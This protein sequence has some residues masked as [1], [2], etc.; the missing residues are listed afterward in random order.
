[1]IYTMNEKMETTKPKPGI[2]DGAVDATRRHESLDQ[3]V[4]FAVFLEP[5]LADFLSEKLIERNTL[6]RKLLDAHIKSGGQLLPIPMGTRPVMQ[7]A[8]ESLAITNP[9]AH[10]SLKKIADLEK[11]KYLVGMPIDALAH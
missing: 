1:M 7:K 2:L 4:H 3:A 10:P 5:G 6:A 9:G 11:L 8:I